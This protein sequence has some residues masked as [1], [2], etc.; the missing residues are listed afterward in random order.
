METNNIVNRRYPIYTAA[1]TKE[2]MQI[3]DYGRTKIEAHPDGCPWLKC[4]G[5]RT[6][7]VCAYRRKGEWSRIGEVG[8]IAR[9]PFTSAELRQ[10]I[11]SLNNGARFFCMHRADEGFNRVCAG[12]HSA[13]EAMPSL[14]S[15][16]AKEWREP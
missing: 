5:T 3:P 10:T 4:C 2:E 13:K 7:L 6:N 14:I 15:T 16:G 8:R 1:A 9:D 11:E 12:W